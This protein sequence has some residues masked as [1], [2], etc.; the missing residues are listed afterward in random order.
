VTDIYSTE[1]GVLLTA[2]S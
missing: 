1:Y 2:L